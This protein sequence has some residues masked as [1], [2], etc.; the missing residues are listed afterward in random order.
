MH[1]IRCDVKGRVSRFGTC[2]SDDVSA[3][4]LIVIG[5][6]RSEYTTPAI[7]NLIGQ[8]FG[9]VS[10][11]NKKAA[12]VKNEGSFA[13]LCANVSRHSRNFRNFPRLVDAFC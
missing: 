12:H 10:E 13:T 8:C 9:H 11:R 4:K 1:F 5:P 3:V 7:Y 2:A 6:I